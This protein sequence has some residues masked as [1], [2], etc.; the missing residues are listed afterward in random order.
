MNLR[1][2]MF[3]VVVTALGAAAGCGSD[4]DPV[5]AEVGQNVIRASDLT[6]AYV[7]LKPESR[8]PVATLDDKKA[9]LDDL[10]NKQL[11]EILSQKKYPQVLPRLQ[12]RITRYAE[13]QLTNIAKDALIRKRI[14]IT[15]AMKDTIYDDMKRELHIKAMLVPDKDAAEYVYKQLQDGVPFSDLARDY[16]SEWPGKGEHGDLGWVSPGM[17]PYPVDVAVW[18]AKVGDVVGPLERPRGNYIIKV[19]GE[20]EKP[21]ASSRKEMEDLLDQTILEQLYLERTKFVQDSL[22]TAVKVYYPA[23]G[24]ALL[25]MKY[26]W[27]PPPDQVDNPYRKLDAQRVVPTFTAQEDSVVVVDF[28]GAPDW[29]AHDF[30]QRLSWY[31]MGLWPTGESEEELVKQLDL[32]VRD[33]LYIKAAEDLGYKNAKFQADVDNRLKQMRVNY[34]YF[35]DL[36]PQFAPD[37]TQVMEYFEKNRE[38]YRAPQSYKMSFFGS[39]DKDLIEDIAK[40]WKNG[41]SWLDIKKAYADKSDQELLSVGETEWLFEG[42]D[43]LRDEM[44]APLKEGGVSDVEMRTDIAM[45]VKLIARRPSR[46]YTFAEIAD[47]VKKDANSTITDRKLKAFLDAKRPEYNVKVHEKALAK[48]VMP[49]PKTPWTNPNVPATADNP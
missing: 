42:Q 33:Y 39:R 17:F 31:P 40:R 9:F 43:P 14:H 23:A 44:V 46:L 15:P 7:R 28:T 34:Y 22:K 4:K 8:P 45:V 18:K 10:I 38:R 19:L 20:R 13:G 16:S 1:R 5:L 41:E 37:S 48:V 47:Q 36:S 29:T 3:L 11:M 6:Q 25:M 35:Q 30:V 26:Y 2:I 24:K 12:T 27:E 21:V 49:D 32:M